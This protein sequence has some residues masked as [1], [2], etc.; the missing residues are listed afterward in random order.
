VGTASIL[1]PAMLQ[2]KSAFYYLVGVWVDPEH[3]RRGLGRRLIEAG[4]NWVRERQGN[5]EGVTVK[6]E[7]DCD[8]ERAK[9]LYKAV[10]FTELPDEESE[11]PNRVVMAI[12][13]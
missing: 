5:D 13:L 12:S 10:G 2:T 1:T 8:N 3:R 6:M 9:A 7:V 11:G 4:L